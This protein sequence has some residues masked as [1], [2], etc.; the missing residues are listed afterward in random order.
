MTKRSM[1][2]FSMTKTCTK[3]DSHFDHVSTD[4]RFLCG[5][6]QFLDGSS[7]ELGSGSYAQGFDSWAGLVL[8]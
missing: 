1:Y 3:E 6:V 2:G 5:R 8:N 7:L 4:H